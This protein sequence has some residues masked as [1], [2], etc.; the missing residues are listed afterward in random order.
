MLINP[1]QSEKEMKMS[2][3]STTRKAALAGL[4]AA[5]MAMVLTPAASTA[6]AAETAAVVKLKKTGLKKVAPDRSRLVPGNPQFSAIG[7]AAVC[8]THWNTS[9]G[10][11][12]CATYEG[13]CPANTFTVECKADGCW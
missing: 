3:L 7:S 5:L 12:G 11:T 2:T 13:E 4:A 8:C 6:Q 10:G 1:G 9:T